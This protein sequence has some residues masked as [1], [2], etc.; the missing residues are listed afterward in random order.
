MGQSFFIWNNT[1][2]RSKGIILTAPAPIIKP[3]ERVEHVTIP[4][5]S[6]ELT[7]LED[8]NVYQG[9]IQT[10]NLSVR[11]AYRV[12]EVL[13][14][15][16]GTGYITFSGEPERRQRARAIGAITLEKRSKNLDWWSG[17]TQ[18]YCEPLKELIKEATVTISSSGGTVRNHGDVQSRPLI[19]LKASGSSAEITCGGYTL[20]LTGLTNNYLYNIDCDAE[21]VTG[22][23][24]AGN[25]TGGSSGQFP[26][27]APGVNTIT[28]SG[29]SQL[30]IT[31][32]ERYL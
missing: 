12:P 13:N 22:A 29:W 28:G 23:T 5:R 9:Y 18:F 14:W 7:L 19:T 6:G 3:E 1:D 8:E 25:L 2:C 31:R 27:L 20:N 26:R 17:D 32:R 10:L 30:T 11:G 15:L 4:G 21:K 16:K 24:I